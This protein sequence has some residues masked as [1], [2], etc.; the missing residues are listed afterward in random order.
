MDDENCEKR[1]KKID[2]NSHNKNW[3]KINFYLKE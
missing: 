3:V 2:E 1:K